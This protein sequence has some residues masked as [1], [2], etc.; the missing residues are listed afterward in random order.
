MDMKMRKLQS[1][2][3][4]GSFAQPKAFCVIFT[5]DFTVSDVLRRTN[6]RIF[7]RMTK[8][9]VL[10]CKKG[11]TA[12]RFCGIIIKLEIGITIQ[13]L[14]V[15]QLVARYLGVVEAAGSSPVTQT[16]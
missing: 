16:K 1:I 10:F 13:Y 2:T 4:P 9:F 11:L 12:Q 5:L 3:T 8:F 7:T 14:G 6:R 15:A